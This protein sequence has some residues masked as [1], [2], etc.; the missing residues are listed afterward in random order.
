MR[1]EMLRD[2]YNN[3]FFIKKISFSCK[4]SLLETKKGFLIIQANVAISVSLKMIGQCIKFVFAMCELSSG[5][6]KLIAECNVAEMLNNS[7]LLGVMCV[8]FKMHLK[9]KYFF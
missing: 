4:E 8:K 5:A 2:G 9:L 6:V 7:G 1:N 3:S